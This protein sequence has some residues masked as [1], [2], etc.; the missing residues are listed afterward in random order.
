MKISKIL[1][2]NVINM[3]NLKGNKG[4]PEKRKSFYKNKVYTRGG[5]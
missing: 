2:K 5:G 3:K 1:Y 4:C